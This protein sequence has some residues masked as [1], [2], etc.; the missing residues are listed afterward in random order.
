MGYFL[1]E[2]KKKGLQHELEFPFE[3][4]IN[5]ELYKDNT[6]LEKKFRKKEKRSNKTGFKHYNSTKKE[7]GAKKKKKRKLFN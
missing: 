7:D 5:C 4:N 2:N 3:D 1:Q 6:G